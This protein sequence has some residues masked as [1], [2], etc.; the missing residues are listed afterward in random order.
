MH[1][2]TLALTEIQVEPKF[3]TSLQDFNEVLTGQITVTISQ[4]EA[5]SELAVEFIGIGNQE[6]ELDRKAFNIET[7]KRQNKAVTTTSGL[8]VTLDVPKISHYKPQYVG[9]AREGTI[10]PN[11]QK[12][13]EQASQRAQS[14]PNSQIEQLRVIVLYSLDPSVNPHYQLRTTVTSQ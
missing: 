4:W 6:L 12:R 2:Y 1:A 7:L 3:N 13:M 8:Q 9:S 10:N 11:E 14:S 5:N